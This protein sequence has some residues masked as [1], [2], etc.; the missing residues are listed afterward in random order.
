MSTEIGQDAR[1]F[2]DNRANWDDRAALHEASGYGID[3]LLT[4]PDAISDEVAA[5]VPYL[6]DLTGLDVIHLQC[7]LGTDTVSLTR[8]GARRVVGVD[9]SGESLRRARSLA[10]RAGARLE[11][12]ESN[13]YDA[14]GAVTGDFDLVYTTVGVLCWLPD[15]EAWA[16]VVASMLRPGGRLHLRDDHPVFM[17]VGDD[18]SG[19]LTLHE[20]YFQQAEP[21]TWDDEGSYV[22]T[23]DGAE[24]VRH[25][26]N[27]QWNHGVGE[28]L[29]ALIKAGLVIDEVAE[30]R[31]SAWCRWSEL[32]EPTDDG[33][34]RFSDPAQRAQLP[35][36]L[37]VRAHRSE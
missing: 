12:V 1:W 27:H 31:T 9:L 36:Q 37:L 7:H 28:I 5:D 29:T 19:G 6:G 30:P 14:R 21:M 10:E 2:D 17:A 32:M 15:I 34:W 26:R 20:P 16:Q 3:R 8:L 24:P 4:A 33:A 13:V 22:A 18:V 35:L 11:L 23:P 25:T